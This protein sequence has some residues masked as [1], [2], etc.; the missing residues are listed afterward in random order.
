M[1]ITVFG[2]S[3]MVGKQV[4][5]KALALGHEVVAF[6]RNVTGMIDADLRNDKFT[7]MKGYVFDEGDVYE[8]I[9][10]SDAVISALGGAV[11]GSSRARSLG[12]KNITEQ[13]QK[14]GVQRIV[15]L[16]GMGIL[17]GEEAGKMFMENAGYP[18]KY[19]AVDKEHAEAYEY[20]K[21]AG[22]SWTFVGAPEIVEGEAD[23]L[24]IT[25]ADEPPEPNSYRINSGNLA[26]FMVNEAAKNAY[27][28][29]RVGIANS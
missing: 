5:R 11:D 20:I 26:L 12:M 18:K 25:K 6:G 4:I 29:L 10:N 8:A 19:K 23:G 17:Q 7:T 21:N 22:L 14:A 3:G 16:G 24:Y 13:M 27:V 9:K 1:K 28:N 15:A 2:S